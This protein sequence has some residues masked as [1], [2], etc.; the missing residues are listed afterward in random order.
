MSSS[1]KNFVILVLLIVCAG[2][3]WGMWRQLVAR[4]AGEAAAAEAAVKITRLEK[5]LALAKKQNAANR[6]SRSHSRP[7][8]ERSAETS[9]QHRPLPP[10]RGSFTA[11]LSNPEFAQAM[12]VRQRASLDRRYA[13]LFA[14]LN[15]PPA[16]LEKLKDLLV[17][18]S[19][20]PMDV[21]AAAQGQDLSRDQLSQLTQ[22]AREEVE[23]SIQ[24]LLGDAQYEQY[25]SYVSSGPQRQLVEQVGARFSYIEPMSA[26][27]SNALTQA[28]VASGGTRITDEVISQMRGV[29]SPAQMESLRQMQSEQQASDTMRRVADELR[30][31][32]QR[33]GN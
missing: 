15:L 16:E 6:A 20:A 22:E 10:P 8:G 5:S 30:Q 9:P 31:S 4:Q 13:G 2:L 33:E 3:G 24:A 21:R 32:R 11:L 26:E 14:Q 1:A 12:A 28:L 25:Q 23:Q 19:A 17:D 7:N 27:Q 18:R 29:M